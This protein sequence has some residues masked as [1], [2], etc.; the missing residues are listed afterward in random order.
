MTSAMVMVFFGGW[1]Q[2]QEMNWKGKSFPELKL[3]GWVPASMVEAVAAG[4]FSELAAWYGYDDKSFRKML[5]DD[6]K[7]LKADRKGYL[8]YVCPS[9]VAATGLPVGPAAVVTQPVYPLSQTFLLHSR[10]GATKVIY[11]DF[12]GHVTSGTAWNTS[13]NG[14]NNI[15][16]PAYDLD[17]NVLA[18]ND[19]ELAR[20]QGIWK[21]VAEDFMVY[22]V[23]VTTE[24]P[25]VDALMKAPSTD[26]AY[27]VRVCV[28]GSSNDWFK[29]PA[30]G[31]A[32]LGSYDWSS[33][34][35]CFV[36]S[37]QL[38]SGNEKYTAEAI[39]HEV[40]HTLRLQHDGLMDASGVTTVDY[41][42]GHGNWAPIMGLG[43]YKEVT[44]WSRGEYAMAN[45]LEDDTAVMLGEGITLRADEHGDTT[46]NATALSGTSVAAT[47][48]VATRSDMDVFR[49]TTG[50]GPVSFSVTSAVPSANL[51][52]Q[53][54]LYNAAG[55]L[56]GQTNPAGMAG[57][58]T[59]SLAEGTYFL[60][61]DGVGTGDAV[62]AYNDYGSLGEYA[63]SGTVAPTVNQPPVVVASGTPTSGVAP[64][65]VTFSSNGT[66]DSGG[67]IAS[68]SWVFGDGTT[69]TVANPAK[70]YTT[71]GTYQA[72]LT[73]QD[74]GGLTA[75]ATVTIS[76]AAATT[77]APV[78]PIAVAAGT[79]TTGTV[80]LAVTFS[81]AGS[82]DPDGTIASYSWVFGDGTTSTLANP[83]KTYTTAGT[84]QATLTV[85]DASGLTGTSVVTITARPAN[86][87]PV[88]RAA[89]NVTTGVAPL[90]VTFSSA[91]SSD[92]DGTIATYN[93][94]FGDGTTSTA[95]NPVKSYTTAGT[96]SAR[97]TVVDNG[98]LASA[99]ATVAITVQQA[100]N[101]IFVT[102]IAM[103]GTVSRGVRSAKAVVTV[104]NSSGASVTGA[105]VSG[106]WSGAV[107]RSGTATSSKGLA[108]FTSPTSTVAGTFTFT[109]TGI[110]LS[111]WTYDSRS[112]VETTDFVK[113]Q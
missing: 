30:G 43:Y 113:V 59:A 64:L 17:G 27:G 55:S 11:L 112:N 95:A 34:T 6:G 40:G 3:P 18:F 101:R 106:T 68:Y 80:P 66:F 89:A 69:S 67:A 96:Y 85:R 86:V 78:A 75:T 62:T 49:F 45:N 19:T 61:V 76:V 20:I 9:L 8:H 109:V 88:A 111:S 71:A 39:S 50:P 82:S 83:A 92:S 21:R 58:L 51:D 102:N 94:V 46:V 28:G 53:L 72:R 74:S 4:K 42:E 22:D 29:S 104:K 37:V 110:T 23:D 5:K 79:P 15:V 36:F 31:I 44:Q 87:A 107:A 54:A 2:G 47:G 48:I 25:G 26:T 38:G 65:A 1:V 24:D 81:S 12:A 97:L 10:P 63:L 16:T 60:A 33:D 7:S 35:P 77:A 56:V 52:V 93:W 108:T 32:Y 57:A 14:G 91:G 13:Y 100:T 90:A 103:T 73:A 99:A 70:T 41:Y 84:Y 105:V 98:G